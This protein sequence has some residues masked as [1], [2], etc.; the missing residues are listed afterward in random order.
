[1]SSPRL[2]SIASLPSPPSSV[3]L[4]SPPL[5]VSLP[6]PPSIPSLIRAASPT[7][8]EIESL[9]SSPFTF[10]TSF[11]A[12][13]CSIFSAAASPVTSTAP[14]LGAMLTV[15]LP[16]VPLTVVVSTAP[17]PA[18]PPIAV[19]RSS[20]M[21]LTS[22]ADRSFTTV[23]SIPPSARR[24]T[25]SVSSTSMVMFATLRKNFRRLPFAEKS[26]L[27][28]TPAP[29]KIIVS[30]PASPSTLSLPSPG[31]QVNESSPAPRRPVSSPRLPSIASFSLPPRSESLPSPPLIAS[32][33]APPSS[34]N[35]VSAASPIAPLS[36]SFPARA[37]T[38]SASALTTSIGRPPGPPETAMCG[39]TAAGA[40]PIVSFPAVPSTTTRSVPTAGSRFSL[41]LAAWA[42]A[43]FSTAP[44]PLTLIARA[45]PELVCGRRALHVDGVRSVVVPKVGIQLAEPCACEVV[46]DYAVRSASGAKVEPVDP[47]AERVAVSSVAELRADAGELEPLR[48]VR[49]VPDDDITAP[50]AEERRRLPVH[51]DAVALVDGQ[52]VA[53]RPGVDDYPVEARAIE[54]ELGGAVAAHVDLEPGRVAP[55]QPQ[56]DPVAPGRA[57]DVQ[58]AAVDEGLDLRLGLLGRLL[59]RLGTRPVGRRAR[60]REC[61]EE[62]EERRRPRRL[63]LVDLAVSPLVREKRRY[64]LHCLLL[65]RVRALL[66]ASAFDGRRRGRA[67]ASE[68]PLDLGSQGSRGPRRLPRGSPEATTASARRQW[69]AS[70]HVRKEQQ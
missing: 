19:S 59:R 29:L 51:E 20:S 5:I 15:S 54:R 3:S 37:S 45:D 57:Q 67:D 33:P 61:D 40:T 49:A 35:W 55:L 34:V 31:S 23:L 65:D 42:R 17:S 21:F 44:M 41:S 4:P 56:R 27:S 66:P 1:M 7:A 16:A 10:R 38:A 12:S 63:L 25:R 47:C 2:P 28:A 14:A 43:M 68:E 46:D 62:D 24:S 32:L 53:A 70:T 69:P 11:A 64:G 9:P 52:R 18:P 22:V 36:V 6:A 26:K 8:P 39:A 50:V 58:L 48:G 30:V 60:E 13:E